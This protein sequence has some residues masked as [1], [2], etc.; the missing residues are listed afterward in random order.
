MLAPAFAFADTVAS[1]W[2]TV[3]TVVPTATVSAV[4][5]GGQSAVNTLQSALTGVF[6]GTVSKAVSG[7]LSS[8]TGALS[9]IGIFGGMLAPIMVC[10]NGVLYMNIGIPYTGPLMWMP[11]VSSV[12]PYLYALGTPPPPGFAIGHYMAPLPC[13]VGPF[14]VMVAPVI[15]GYG[16]AFP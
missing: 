2:G 4:Q 5:K 10:D 1:P 3:S 14:P 6:G 9:G 12:P 8:A 13:F 11:G 7:V 15:H 16:T